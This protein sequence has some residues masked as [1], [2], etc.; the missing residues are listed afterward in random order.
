MIGITNRRRQLQAVLPVVAILSL[1]AA[2]AILIPSLNQVPSVEG[3]CQYTPTPGG[4]S[5]LGLKQQEAAY[6]EM[7]RINTFAATGPYVG[8]LQVDTKSGVE[9]S[10]D[11]SF[12]CGSGNQSL[13]LQK[14][15]GSLTFHAQRC[16]AEQR[17][18]EI[19]TAL[20]DACDGTIQTVYEWEWEG[21][22][23]TSIAEAKQ[24]EARATRAARRKSSTTRTTSTRTTS[25]RTCS[26][27]P[28]ALRPKGDPSIRGRWTGPNASSVQQIS[29]A[30]RVYMEAIGLILPVGNGKASEEEAAACPISTV[31]DPG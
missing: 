17:Y 7:D 25:S 8:R 13:A 15:S 11:P 21:P 12:S 10:T 24:T 1:A 4:L 31:M 16:D 22:V 5:D 28:N 27:T 20:V 6:W 23:E 9:L 14:G 19:T 30:Q 2:A 29:D 26:T 3:T 18:I